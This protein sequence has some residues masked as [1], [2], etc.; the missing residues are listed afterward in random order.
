MSALSQHNY[1]DIER[2][3]SALDHLPPPLERD[4]WVKLLMAARD[5]GVSEDDART[6]SERGENF[7]GADF[8]A[9][10]HSI[11]PGAVTQRTL[12][13]DAIDAGWNAPT[14]GKNLT[15]T[16]RA[17]RDAEYARRRERAEVEK[18]E[19][20]ATAAE[21]A[22]FMWDRAQPL[23]GDGHPYL[24]RKGVQSYGLRVGAYEKINRENGAVEVISVQA[25]LVPIWGV[26]KKIQSLQ[27]I[28]AGKV[29]SGRDKDFVTDGAISGMF[30][31]FGK[32]VA[33]DVQGVQR[34]VI[35]I[36]EGYAS[37]ASLHEVTGHACIVALTAANLVLV[38]KITRKRFPEAHII[39]FSD[40][41]A[42]DLKKSVGT[43]KAM[44]AAYATGA[45]VVV[46]EWV[47]GLK[48]RDANDIHLYGFTWGGET[49]PGDVILDACVRY[50]TPCRSPAF[51]E[52]L[53]ECGIEADGLPSD[54]AV[55]HLANGALEITARAMGQDVHKMPGVHETAWPHL[56]LKR[57]KPLNTIPNLR[58]MLD[59]YHFTVRYDVIRKEVQVT[60]PGQRGTMD[61]VKSKAIDT[62]ISLCALNHLPKTDTPSYLLS[63]AD[64]NQHNPVMDYITS[65]QWDGTSRFE[66][67]LAT[68]QTKP[69]FDRGLLALLLRR[70]LVSAVAAAAKSTGF[71]S[72]GVLV[73]QGSQSLGKTAWFR[74]LVPPTMRDLVKVGALIDPKEKDTIISA[75]SH[76]L[77][78]LGELDGTLGKTDT[79]RLKSFVSQDVDQFRRPYGRAE[80]KFPRHTVFFAS[81]NPKAFLVDETGN[82]RWWTI[83]VTGLNP[84]HQI[85]MQ[86]LWAE[87]YEWFNADERWWLEHSEEG[88]LEAANADHER[89]DPFDEMIASKYDFSNPGPRKLTATQVLQELGYS[90]PSK[91][92]LGESGNALR[93][94]FG[95]PKKSGSNRLYS[96]PQMLRNHYG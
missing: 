64:D 65:K 80:E 22:Q 93:K 42:E 3:L 60:H 12:F 10:W 49:Y 35:L 27:A 44:Q 70:W 83:P 96:V 62:V 7:D 59:N 26:G 36:G 54:P 40:R 76:W 30:Y 85:D 28:F 55:Q 13:R 90:T 56:D 72:K 81:V 74:S 73:F 89:P 78:E 95:E 17:Q 23:E 69:G 88:L 61:N 9:T 37:L 86:Q 63:I 52:L 20:R 53:Q 34:V 15:D 38:A 91:K 48:G 75:V 43:R 92:Q 14:N 29:C 46:P 16:E 67:L 21:H 57:M 41:D 18:A 1:D 25:L 50:A 51:M 82:V 87:V 31:S 45:S 5:A 94:H 8:R 68:V 47:A 32:P 58:Y 71:W 6:W 39:I 24:Q 4:A 84:Q 11:Q 66:D 33:V 19:A 77:V 2:A 79:A